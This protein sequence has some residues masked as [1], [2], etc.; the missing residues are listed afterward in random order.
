MKG[1]LFLVSFWP[2]FSMTNSAEAQYVAANDSYES[3]ASDLDAPFSNPTTL[4]IPAPR[5]SVD[6]YSPRSTRSSN[7]ST[8]NTNDWLNEKMDD[9]LFKKD[10]TAE[11]ELRRYIKP[12]FDYIEQDL[13]YETGELEKLNISNSFGRNVLEFDD[14]TSGGAALMILPKGSY[15]VEFIFEDK[16]YNTIMLK[17]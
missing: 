1:I 12:F 17:K 5:S 16:V 2:L 8:A 9:P 7:L 6:A 14:L 13:G 15:S 4:V 10:N 11:T 3:A